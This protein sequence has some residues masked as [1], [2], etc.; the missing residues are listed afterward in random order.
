MTED[1]AKPVLVPKPSM[2]VV[3]VTIIEWI[4]PDGSLVT[5]GQ[6]ICRVDADKVELEIVAPTSGRL[7][8]SGQPDATYDVGTQIG[9]VHSDA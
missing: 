9:E 2:Q 1:T 5:D 6:P 4:V 3:E 8:I 7:V